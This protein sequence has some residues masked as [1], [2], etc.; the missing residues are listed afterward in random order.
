MAFRFPLHTADLVIAV[1]LDRKSTAL[2][3]KGPSADAELVGCLPGIVYFPATWKS[4]WK[5]TDSG[6][7]TSIIPY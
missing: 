2:N 5:G 7:R 1:V 6:K 3:I 4:W